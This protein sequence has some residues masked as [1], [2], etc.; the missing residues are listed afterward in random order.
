M[1]L[2]EK[3]FGIGPNED[4]YKPFVEWCQQEGV[5]MPKIEY[6][7]WFEGDLLG[8]KVIEDIQHREAYIYVPYKLIITLEST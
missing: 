1:N 5:I 4:R 6:P 8:A 3:F 2:A 7:A